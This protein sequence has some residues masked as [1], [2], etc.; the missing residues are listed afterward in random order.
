MTIRPRMPAA[1][2]AAALL[3]LAGCSDAVADDIMSSTTVDD[4]QPWTAAVPDEVGGALEQG[5]GELG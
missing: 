5:S 2:A 3:T 4:R 1:L